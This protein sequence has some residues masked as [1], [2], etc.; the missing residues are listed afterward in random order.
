MEAYAGES[1]HP[2]LVYSSSSNSA[3]YC[4]GWH[5]AR[6]PCSDIPLVSLVDILQLTQ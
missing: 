6:G 2:G 1:L 3:I 4:C 5:S